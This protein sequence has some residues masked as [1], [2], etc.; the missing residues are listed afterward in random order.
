MEHNY[1]K[2]CPKCNSNDIRQGKQEGYSALIAGFAKSSRVTYYLC[3]NCGYVVDQFVN[4]P[5]KFKP[6]NQ[7]K[8]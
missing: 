8:L 4:Q 2:V 1:T 3:G 6:V 7:V 5:E